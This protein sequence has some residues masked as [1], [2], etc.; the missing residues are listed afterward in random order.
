M[1]QA[2]ILKQQTN[3]ATLPGQ[4]KTL[5]D[6]ARL[7][8]ELGRDQAVLQLKQLQNFWLQIMADKSASHKDRLAASKLYAESIGAFDSSTKTKGINGAML[9]WKKPI[10]VENVLAK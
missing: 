2:S 7:L 3:I 10:D 9:H 8:Q 5:K 1:R 6:C 4:P